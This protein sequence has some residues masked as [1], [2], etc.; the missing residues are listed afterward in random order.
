M[1]AFGWN[2][3][4]VERLCRLLP[5]WFRS[6]HLVVTGHSRPP[7]QASEL[8]MAGKSPMDAEY[9]GWPSLQQ[10]QQR[11]N[12]ESLVDLHGRKVSLA[13]LPSPYV[14][15]LDQAHDRFGSDAAVVSLTAHRVNGRQRL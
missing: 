13:Q 7:P 2:R 10:A 9:L 15:R 11:E 12:I 1:A 3:H 8:A 6:K 14:V 5:R 4:P